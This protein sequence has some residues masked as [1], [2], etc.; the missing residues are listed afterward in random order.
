MKK[1][2]IVYIGLIFSSYITFGQD[3]IP[4][5][6]ELTDTTFKVGDIHVFDSCYLNMGLTDVKDTILIKA[7]ESIYKFMTTNTSVKIEIGAHVDY[8]GS[9]EYNDTLTDRRS[10]GIKD[11]LVA[12]G[13]SESRIATFG[14]GE[15]KPRYITKKMHRLHRFLTTGNYLTEGF[16][17]KL[18]SDIDRQAACRLDRRIE[19]KILKK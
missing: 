15:R 7:T 17:T 11:Y 12:K 4:R 6:F 5:Y 13:I 2:F 9:L 3:S 1:S 18:D 8:R 14:Y 16:I 19:I 10:K